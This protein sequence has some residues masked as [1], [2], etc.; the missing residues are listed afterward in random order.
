MSSVSKPVEVLV[1]QP[2][3]GVEQAVGTQAAAVPV[4]VELL[5]DPEHRQ[6]VRPAG[7]LSVAALL[8]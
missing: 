2:V 5:A 1:Q 8:I 3:V 6:S 4:A 7:H